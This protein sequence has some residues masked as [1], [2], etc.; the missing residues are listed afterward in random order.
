MEATNPRWADE[1]QT[2]LMLDVL[3]DGEASE[4]IARE[5]DVFDAAALFP[6]AIAGAFGPIAAWQPP[7]APTRAE[8]KAA[9]TADV[10][11]KR[12]EVETGGIVVG[13]ATIMTDRGSQAMVNGAYAGA[14]RNPD[15]LIDF[16]G[17]SGWVTLDAATMIAIGDAVFA[18]VQACFTRERALHQAIEAAATH[19]ALDAVDV[20]AGWPS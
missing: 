5:S 9:L 1:A 7:A 10:S 17:A 14:L 8:R 16:K 20:E 3:V 6:R 2:I 13:G 4:Y 19:A 11:Q 15:V 18:H 12:W